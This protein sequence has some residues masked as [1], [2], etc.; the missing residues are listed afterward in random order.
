MI[1]PTKNRIIV[2]LLTSKKGTIVVT[3]PLVIRS[4]A[5]FSIGVTGLN[6]AIK[7]NGKVSGI[8]YTTGVTKNNN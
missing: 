6:T 5:I 3:L 4:L 1:Q 7:E 2:K 8:G